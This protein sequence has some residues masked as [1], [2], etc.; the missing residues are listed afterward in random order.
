MFNPNILDTENLQCILLI[1]DH[2]SNE[3]VH[4]YKK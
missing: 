4:F 3:I 1:D 2:K